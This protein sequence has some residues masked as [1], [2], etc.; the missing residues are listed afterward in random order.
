MKV[1]I[2]TKIALMMAVFTGCI[3]GASWFLC[4]YLV[5]DIF[6][7]NVKTNLVYTYESCN[8]LFVDNDVSDE[9]DDGDLFGRIS[10]PTECIVLIFDSVNSKIYTS[11]NDEG[12]MMNSL[13][14][15]L[16]S[17]YENKDGKINGPGRYEIK[18]NHDE[19]INADYY[20]LVGILDNGYY[21]ILRS[22]IARIESA[23]MVITK[24]FNYVAIGMVLF[25]M[26]FLLAYGNI[27]SIPIKKLTVAAKRMTALDFDAK[28]PVKTKDEIGEL[29]M[30]MN[31]MSEKLESTISELKAANLELQKDIDNK[32][33]IDEM[34]KEFLSH[35]SHELKTPIALIQGYAEG[36]KDNLFD[37]DENRE[38]Y[39][40][41][42]IDEAQKM[43]SMV[44]KLLNLNEIEF[45]NTPLKIER[46]ELNEFIRDIIE[47]TK[48]LAED[49]KAEIEFEAADEKFVWADV[50]MTEEVFTNYLTNAIHYVR[51]GGK[52][53]IWTE[54]NQDTVRVFVY[55][56]G[57]NIPEG[58]LEKLFVKFYKVDKARTREY[59]GN[60]IGLS[61]VAAIMGAHNKQYGV[62]NVE[63]GV[64]FYFDLDTNMPC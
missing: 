34:R 25:G 48:I 12:R 51:E 23:M 13:N 47:S 20:D 30:C 45:G 56:D 7:L 5:E 19:L 57:D 10:N 55:N 61:I 31:T 21:V 29:S 43:N 40:D 2:R 63:S 62:Y 36:L 42:I 41:V 39:T 35:V 38:F 16:R 15:M 44:K 17:L 3:I 32:R 11:I 53:R 26:L 49:V 64:V 59:G 24:V 28:V 14:G 1:S 58:D 60:G 46:F 33:Q 50:F 54:T 22:P 9:Y 52:I 27:Y 8:E 37:D 6:V 4:N 18:K